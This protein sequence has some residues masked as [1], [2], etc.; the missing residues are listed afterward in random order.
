MTQVLRKVGNS[1]RAGGA[2]LVIQ[3]SQEDPVV[4]VEIDAKVEFREVTDEQNFR[5]YLRAA[6]EAF[7][8]SVGERLFDIE[9]EATTPEGESYHCK[10]YDSLDEW[11]EDRL[12]FCEDFEAFTS[13]SERIQRLVNGRKHRIFEYW[14]EYILLLRKL[15]EGQDA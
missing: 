4:E 9:W 15:G 12:P 13:M 3:P 8:N 6:G 7:R 10:E 14:R 11:V 2:V 5:G 1:L